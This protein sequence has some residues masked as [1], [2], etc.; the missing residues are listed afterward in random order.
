[1][2]ADEERQDGYD[3]IERIAAQPGALAR[4]A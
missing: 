2:Y 1:M 4:L 3:M